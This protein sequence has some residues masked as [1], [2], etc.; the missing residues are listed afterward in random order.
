MGDGDAILQI[1]AGDMGEK[2]SYT[3]QKFCEIPQ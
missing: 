3:K 2:K 1:Q